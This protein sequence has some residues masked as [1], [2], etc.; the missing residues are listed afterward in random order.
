[1]CVYYVIYM[2]FIHKQTQRLIYID[3][4]LIDYYFQYTYNVRMMSYVLWPAMDA[5]PGRK[6]GRTEREIERE[7][8]SSITNLS[9]TYSTPHTYIH[10]YDRYKQCVIYSHLLIYSLTHLCSHISRFWRRFSAKLT[11][12][13]NKNCE[14]SVYGHFPSSVMWC[15]CVWKSLHR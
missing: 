1:M 15:V 11:V 2:M 13:E 10:T 4:G 7:R 6:E 3:F 12:E 8:Y 14:T 9:R 5:H